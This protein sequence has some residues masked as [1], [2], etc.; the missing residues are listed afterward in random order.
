MYYLQSLR[1]ICKEIFIF[2]LTNS[3][4]EKYI[5]KFVMRREPIKIKQFHYRPGQALRVPGI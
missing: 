1:I 3:S 2:L 5:K 4:S